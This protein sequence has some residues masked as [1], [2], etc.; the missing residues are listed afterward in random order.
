MTRWLPS[1]KSTSGQRILMKGRIAGPKLPLSCGIQAP[2]NTWFL[3]PT[4]VHNPNGISIGS[5]DLAQLTVVTNRQT[6]RRTHWSRNIGDNVHAIWPNNVTLSVITGLYL[7]ESVLKFVLP[8]LE[9]SSVFWFL[10]LHFTAIFTYILG[11]LIDY[12]PKIHF[13]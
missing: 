2:L 13:D 5:A 7:Y 10:F 9:V 12:S 8:I 1:M 4:W 3:G 6:Y 11:L